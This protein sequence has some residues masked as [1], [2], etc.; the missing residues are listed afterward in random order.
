MRFPKDRQRSQRD[1]GHT[2]RGPPKQ[3]TVA[4]A[5][6]S[7][8]SVELPSRDIVSPHCVPRSSARVSPHSHKRPSPGQSCSPEPSQAPG[9]T[10]RSPTSVAAGSWRCQ[11][12]GRHHALTPLT[13]TERGALLSPTPVG[14]P[15]LPP[16]EPDVDA[17]IREAKDFEAA[18]ELRER[19]PRRTVRRVRRKWDFTPNLPPSLLRSHTEVLHHEETPSGLPALPPVVRVCRDNSNH[20]G[21]GMPSFQKPTRC[22]SIRKFASRAA[23]SDQ[24]KSVPDAA[25]AVPVMDSGSANAVSL[26]IPGTPT[27]ETWYSTTLFTNIPASISRMRSERRLSPVGLKLKKTMKNV[28]QANRVIIDNKREKYVSQFPFTREEY[29][30]LRGCFEAIDEDA[31]GELDWNEIQDLGLLTGFSMQRSMFEKMDRDG[32]GSLDFVE[33]LRGFYPHCPI[34]DINWAVRNWGLPREDAPGDMDMDDK[35]HWEDDFEHEDA[36]EIAEMFSAFDKNGS[37]AVAFEELRT[38]LRSRQL[39]TD[40]FIHDLIKEHDARGVGSLN[41]SGFASLMADCYK[42][43]RSERVRGM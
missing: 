9:A 20:G 14:T 1:K 4:A 21:G 40:D 12:A 2:K 7:R 6:S 43:K 24:S 31:N 39:F 10:T 22:T 23:T 34:R 41:I 5:A 15:L 37:G 28:V 13:G 8:L 33:M 25:A 36:Q 19:H 38:I 3:P 27:G 26:Q 30:R 42:T 11:K 32:S 16:L 29:D 17:V 35:R 18:Q